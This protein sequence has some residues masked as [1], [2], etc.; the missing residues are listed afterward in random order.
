MSIK[1][2][3]GRIRLE[4]VCRVEEAEPL[5]ALLQA[6]L[7]PVD[8]GECREAHT[9]VLQV[10]LA[11]RP[12]IE[13]APSAPV[14]RALVQSLSSGASASVEVKNSGATRGPLDK[15]TSLDV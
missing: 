14:L 5:A 2:E 10:L 6:G 8:L 12:P 4:G 3:G 7:R 11:F 15:T 13:G 1:D 9:A